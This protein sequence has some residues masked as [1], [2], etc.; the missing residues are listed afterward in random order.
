MRGSP[1]LVRVILFCSTMNTSEST[2]LGKI[3]DISQSDKGYFK[4]TIAVNT[5][6]KTRFLKFCLWDNEPLKYK[7]ESFKEGNSVRVNYYHQDNFPKF[8]SMEPQPI[9]QC[10]KCFTFYEGSDAQRIDCPEYC[11]THTEI[12]ERVDK[13]VKLVSNTIKSFRY[14]PGRCL[15]FIDD[16]SSETFQCTICIFCF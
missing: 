14:S 1:F 11:S 16:N 4:L 7:G 3:Y 6:F 13:T 5:P 2:S 10:P 9:D 12:K 8:L 15:V